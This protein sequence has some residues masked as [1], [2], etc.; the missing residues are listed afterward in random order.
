MTHVHK[1]NLHADCVA[2]T[3]YGRIMHGFTF[4]EDISVRGVAKYAEVSPELVV[5]A[6]SKFAFRN[7]DRRARKTRAKGFPC[8]VSSSERAFSAFEFGRGKEE[9]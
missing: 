2:C 6:I 7:Q 4:A 5:K 3:R 9:H 1:P 8:A